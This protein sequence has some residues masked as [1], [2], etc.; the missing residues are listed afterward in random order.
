M[1]QAS[2]VKPDT[3]ILKQI[4]NNTFDVF[5]GD[6]GWYP[7]TR[8]KKTNEGKVVKIKGQEVENELYYAIRRR[9]LAKCHN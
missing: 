3:F 4:D 6:I 7:W 5:T 2:V 9:I 8:F 1:Q